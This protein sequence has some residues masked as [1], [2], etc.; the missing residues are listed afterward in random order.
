MSELVRYSYDDKYEE[1]IAGRLAAQLRDS[2][3]AKV[4]GAPVHSRI[5]QSFGT[6][7]DWLLIIS[8]KNL[9]EI[10]TQD[11][12]NLVGDWFRDEEVIS[13]L[14]DRFTEIF[15][16]LITRSQV[17]LTAKYMVCLARFTSNLGSD[18]SALDFLQSIVDNFTLEYPSR[19]RSEEGGTNT[20]FALFWAYLFNSGV[21]L[22]K[23]I[24]FLADS[25]DL[26]YHL[27]KYY[28]RDSTLFEDFQDQ[29]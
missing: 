4:S 13:V 3:L 26:S 8:P 12:Y 15:L 17:Q 14:V 20:E 2:A 18:A 23:L 24:L 1:G 16:D 9:E 5:L 22:D 6:F 27:L 21:N 19:I 11:V 25:H 29:D 7:A 28:V 10:L